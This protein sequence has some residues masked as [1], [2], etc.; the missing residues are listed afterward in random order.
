MLL[1][2]ILKAIIYVHQLQLVLHLLEEELC[3]I[4]SQEGISL[5]YAVPHL[6]TYVD[7]I[8]KAASQIMLWVIYLQPVSEATTGV[9][10]RDDM[11]SA[12]IISSFS[13]CSRRLPSC[14]PGLV[15][16]VDDNS[17]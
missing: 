17:D 1:V 2:L 3:S 12:H 16:M 4:D 5:I 13:Y 8:M 6:L 9:W 10:Q 11:C 14:S 7:L 15:M